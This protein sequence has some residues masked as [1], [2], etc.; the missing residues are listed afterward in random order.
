MRVELTSP[1]ATTRGTSRTIPRALLLTFLILAAGI[2]AAGW[3]FSTQTKKDAELTAQQNLAAIAD[4][5]V[6]QIVSWR[7][8]RLGDAALISGNPLIVSRLAA[9]LEKPSPGDGGEDIQS[10]LAS[11]RSSYAYTSI[12]LL[13]AQG[14]VRV[15]VGFPEAHLDP[16]DRANVAAVA[17]SGKPLLSDFHR[18]EKT[19]RVQL[20]LCAPL[21]R[22][23]D[24]AGTPDCIGVILLEIDPDVFLYP[25]IQAWPTPSRSAETLLVRRDGE[26]VL[27]L[28]ELRHQQDTALKLRLPLSRV[29][30]LAVMAVLGQEGVFRGLDYRGVQVLAF[31]SAV[32]D[33]PWWMVAKVDEAEALAEWRFRGGFV[34]AVVLALVLALALAAVGRMTWEQRKQQRVLWQSVEAV[35]ASEAR[36]RAILDA[37]PFPIALVDAQDHNIGFW[38]RSAITL[39][40]RVAPNATEWF[41]LAYP[42]PDYRREV[43]ARWEPAL[44]QARRSGQA[45]NTGEYRVTRGDGSV[46][47]CELHAAFLADKLIITFHDI[48]ERKRAVETLARYAEELKRSNDELQDFAYVASHDLQEP[49]RKIQAF[50]ERLH[51]KCAAE[52]GTQGQDYLR[53][54]QDAARRMALLIE[55]LLS[56]SRVTTQAKR[57]EPVDLDEVAREVIA[58][59]ET[60][61]QQ[62]QGRVE[63]RGLP[64]LDADPT[65]MRQLLQNL[66]GNALKFHRPDAPPVVQ[67][68]RDQAAEVPGGDGAVCQLV[69]EDNGIGF[70]EKY[71]DRIF[72]I[73][74]RLHERGAYAGSGIGLAICRKI[75][76]RHGGSLT[77]KSQPGAG[78]MFIVTLPLHQPKTGDHA[79]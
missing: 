70:D 64:V 49:L 33:S 72:T 45:V 78:A 76:G 59:L 73:F 23:K 22:P 19:G 16:Q 69:V 39:F 71:L 75:A 48:T 53:R 12:A 60:C 68:Y 58:D 50:G 77:A 37:T 63:L 79:A 74:Q 14:Q 1:G 51:T 36:L 66:I 61:L 29:E 57:F 35:R 17:R 34:V 15:S 38:S 25:L 18:S 54:M 6:G 11:L 26:D 55:D 10:W 43:L 42:D 44:E 67:V 41:Q 9:F 21:L 13:D 3:L 8:E 7:H 2:M 62:T 40:G 24:A 4:L 65:Q 52:L 20:D 56:Y 32:P 31:L 30:V 47:I 5:K 27:F 28:N 46:R